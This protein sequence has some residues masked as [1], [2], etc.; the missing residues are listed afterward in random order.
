MGYWYQDSV[1]SGLSHTAS[2]TYDGVNRLITAV[3]TGSSTYNLT[4]SYDAYGNMTCTTNGQTQGYCPNWAFN[5]STNQLTT[6][7]FTYDAAGNLTKDSSNAA[8]HTYQWDAEG[9]V[10]S[11]DS[12]STWAFTYNAVGNR[13]QWAYSGGTDEHLFDPAGNWLGNAGEYSAVWRGNVA[14]AVYIWGD[15]L[16]NH[17]NHL[18]STTLRTNQAGTPIEDI[19]FYPWGYVWQLWGSGGFNFAELPYTDLTTV[20]ELTPARVFSPNLGR[21]HSPDPMWPVAVRLDDPQTWNMYAY[22][23]N[24]PTGLVDPSGAEYCKVVTDSQGNQSIDT[25]SCVS[26]ADYGNEP[27]QYPGY[28]QVSQ[29]VTITVT[30][31]PDTDPAFGADQGSSGL[32]FGT[33]LTPPNNASPDP[34]LDQRANDLARA[35]NKTGV[36]TLASPCTIGLFYGAS[37]GAAALVTVDWTAVVVAAEA[38]GIPA[39]AILATIFGVSPERL[40]AFLA[41]S[42]PGAASAVQTACSQ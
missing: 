41:R 25:T 24:N 17:A 40:A 33:P 6:S 3:A 39:S 14:L 23:R 7:G 10:A 20:T 5:T 22:V 30:A 38:H 32:G 15:T 4:F 13:V 28:V 9:R 2:Y 21:W 8:A 35:I 37:R 29:D 16:F 31:N 36:Q 11:V 26:D 42:L 1:Q 19:L 18:G 34:T 12:G 27:A